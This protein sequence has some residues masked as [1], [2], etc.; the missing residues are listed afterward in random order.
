MHKGYEKTIPNK[1]NATKESE[2]LE[3]RHPSEGVSRG[4]DEICRTSKDKAEEF[5]YFPGN[6][7]CDS[8]RGYMDGPHPHWQRK[9]VFSRLLIRGTF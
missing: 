2:K 6:Y 4:S 9:H 1:D 7:T 8:G 3:T 5:V